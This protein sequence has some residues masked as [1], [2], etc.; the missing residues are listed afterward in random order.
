[1]EKNKSCTY[2]LPLLSEFVNLNPKYTNYI[3]NTYI[4]D[5][6]DNY[7]NCIMVLHEYKARIPEF[8]KYEFELTKN[9][10]FVDFKDIGN[11]VLYIFKFPEE[12]LH[13][14]KK[15]KE[16][17]YS[18]FKDDSQSLVL[19]FW[20]TV[21]G[22]TAVNFLMLLRQIFKKDPRLKSKLESDLKVKLDDNAELSSI[23]DKEKETYIF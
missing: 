8:T 1:M 7:E 23:M 2:L 6:E 18:E 3:K 15:F 22:S 9:D 4:F 16:G 5:N 20:K 11:D 17:K 21:Y 12:Y 19:R 14:Y 10:L 13:E